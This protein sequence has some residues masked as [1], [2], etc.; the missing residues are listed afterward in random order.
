MYP[1]APSTSEI[2]ASYLLQ[3]LLSEPF[4]KFAVDASMRVAMPKV[5]R[6]ALA[7]ALMWYPERNE[8]ERILSFISQ[9]IAPFDRLISNAEAEILALRE[10]RTRL[11]AD[12][13]TGKLD[14][15]EAAR[16]L[17]DEEN[18]EEGEAGVIE[19]VEREL[20]EV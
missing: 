12:V 11:T 20:A 1:I 4:T 16:Q 19:D 17:P 7:N 10:Y 14:V 3:L 2:N 13:V 15:R 5:N 8:Q 18:V 6:E 9:Q